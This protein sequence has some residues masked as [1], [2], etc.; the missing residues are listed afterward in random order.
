ME[1]AIIGIPE[2]N[3]NWDESKIKTIRGKFENNELLDFETNKIMS[4]TTYGIM[5]DQINGR[6]GWFNIAPWIGDDM[7]IFQAIVVD[8]FPKH[9]WNKLDHIR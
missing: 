6:K 8:E 7:V 4:I 3:Q 5:Y 9:V 2:K 1:Y